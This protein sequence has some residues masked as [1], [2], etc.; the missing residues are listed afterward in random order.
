MEISC[1]GWGSRREREGERERER[2]REIVLNVCNS[3][4][5]AQ[6]KA[7]VRPSFWVSQVDAGTQTLGSPFDAFPGSLAGSW[8]VIGATRSWTGTYK[9]LSIAGSILTPSTTLALVLEFCE[10]PCRSSQ[11]TMSLTC[12]TT[13]DS[14]LLPLPPLNSCWMWM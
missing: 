1:G 7:R 4:S 14:C 11:C 9:E 3:K 10:T 5:W 6:L 12:F 8:M 13:T 2:E